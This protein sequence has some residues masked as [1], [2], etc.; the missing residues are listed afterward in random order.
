MSDFGPFVPTQPTRVQSIIRKYTS[1]DPALAGVMARSNPATTRAVAGLDV[2]RVR[3]GQAPYT[4]NET[5]VGLRAADTN[6]PVVPRQDQ[7]L[8]QNALTDVKAFFS[9]IPK[10]P[11]IGRAHV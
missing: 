6:E 1:P 10:L 11:E 2:D 7:G 3:R 5:A 8:F 9:S 4:Q